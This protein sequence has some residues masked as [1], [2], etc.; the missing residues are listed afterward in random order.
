MSFLQEGQV[1]IDPARFDISMDVDSF[2]YVT[3]DLR[4]LETFNP[5][6]LVKSNMG[7]SRDNHIK[8]KIDVGGRTRS[9][10]LSQ[11][12]NF[13]ILQG[14]NSDV[15]SVSIFFP[16]LT[17]LEDGRYNT[18][19]SDDVQE[20]WFNK[21]MWPALQRFQH[22]PFDPKNSSFVCHGKDVAVSRSRDP[23]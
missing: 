13:V 6:L 5:L 16:A 7:I 10:N 11:I 19:V 12:P 14:G 1:D 15:F 2:R 4:L 8:A 9:M 22:S 20:Q 21:F 18:R 23:N 17:S 3:R